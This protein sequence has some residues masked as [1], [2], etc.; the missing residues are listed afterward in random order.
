[1]FYDLVKKFALPNLEKNSADF[2][3]L[4]KKIV[5]IILENFKEKQILIRGIISLIGFNSCTLEYQENQRKYGKTKYSFF[6]MLN[7][8]ISGIISFTSIPLYI[9]FFTGFLMTIFS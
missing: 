7:F 1:M 5:K 9:I 3:L 2:R 8:G 6:K 4:Y